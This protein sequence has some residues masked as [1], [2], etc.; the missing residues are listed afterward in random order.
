M[1]GKHP[2]ACVIPEQYFVFTCCCAKGHVLKEEHW[3]TRTPWNTGTPW[4]AE[5]PQNP[6]FDGVNKT[7]CKYNLF[8]HI[9]QKSLEPGAKSTEKKVKRKTERKNE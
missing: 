8:T 3:N 1:C 6:K 5:N 2:P 7:E 4:N 9:A